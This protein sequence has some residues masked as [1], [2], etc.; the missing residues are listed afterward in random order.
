MQRVAVV[1][2]ASSGLGAELARALARR[3]WLC[4]LLARREDRLRQLAEETGGEYETC[5]VADRERVDRVAATVIERHPQIGLLVN[6]AGIPG[7]TGNFLAIEPERLE[8]LFAVNFFGGVW[9]TRAFMPALEAA[10]P[11][12]LVNMVSVAGTVAVGPYSA[13][14]HAQIAFSR[15]MAAQLRPRGIRVLTVKPGYVETEGFPQRSHMGP[16][17]RRLVVDPPFVANRIIKAIEHGR[18]ELT[19]P[20][21]YWFGSAAQALAPGLLSRIRTGKLSR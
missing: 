15:T 1:T 19:V 3:G 17:G 8:R 11:S 5:D 20:R 18:G 12:Y 2:G 10:A 7:G 21:Y 4:V 14:K 13:S 16:I 9:V 6:N